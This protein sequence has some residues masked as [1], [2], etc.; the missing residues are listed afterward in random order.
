MCVSFDIG[1][2]SQ[3]LADEIY[4]QICK[5]MTNNPEI[6]SLRHCWQLMSLCVSTFAPSPDFEN[7]LL[8]FIGGHMKGSGE[9]QCWS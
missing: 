9:F 2:A 7:Y 3:V 6:T 4:V 8:N 1:V 5:H